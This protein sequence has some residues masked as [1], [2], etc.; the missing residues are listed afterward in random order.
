M[1]KILAVVV[2]A[3]ILTGCSTSVKNQQAAPSPGSNQELTASSELVLQFPEELSEYVVREQSTY[4]TTTTETF[5]MKCGVDTIPLFRIDTGSWDL[6]DRLGILRTKNGDI[7]ITYTVFVVTEEDMASLGENGPKLYSDLMEGFNILLEGIMNDPRF[8]YEKPIELGETI[9]VSMK[10][11]TVHLPSNMR[12]AENIVDGN[13]EAVFYGNIRGEDIALYTI[14]IGD[15]TAETELGLF[16]IDGVQKPIFIESNDLVEMSNWSEEDYSLA[17]RMMDTIN[18]VIPRI[19]SSEHFT[20]IEN[21][22]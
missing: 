1:K 11:W 18:D 4:G 14:C 22:G 17:Y 7:P 10:Y 12:V 6:G 15:G 20:E 9:D 21:I 5:Y 2:G 8:A 16:M 19:T 13:Y 3:I